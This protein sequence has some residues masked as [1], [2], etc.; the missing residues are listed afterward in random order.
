MSKMP[1]V[2]FGFFSFYFFFKNMLPR[3]N[4]I[5]LLKIQKLLKTSVLKSL[6]F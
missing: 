3:I 5:E 6:T 1:G 2:L 4:G